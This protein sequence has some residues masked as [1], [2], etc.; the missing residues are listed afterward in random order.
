MNQNES[1]IIATLNEL[2]R[3]S[4]SRHTEEWHRKR[5]VEY[6]PLTPNIAEKAGMSIPKARAILTRLWKAEKILKYKAYVGCMVRW[7][8]PERLGCDNCDELEKVIEENHP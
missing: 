8:M 5:P 6:G 1:I 2:S 7:Y 4:D 3:H